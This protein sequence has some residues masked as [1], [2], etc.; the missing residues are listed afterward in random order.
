[1]NETI[2]TILNR[3]STR[4]FKPDMPSNEALEQILT[5]GLYAPS[6]MNTQNWHFSVVKNAEWIAR[7]NRAVREVLPEPA[8]ERM[9]AR[10]HGNPDFSLFYFAPVVIFVSAVAGDGGS[11]VN[12][13]LATQNICLA[14]ESLGLG[15]CI[16]GMAA[17]LTDLP[18]GPAYLKEIKIPEGYRPLHAISLGY[19]DMEMPAPARVPGKVEIIE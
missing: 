3:R 7:A 19:K 4:A 15:T 14:A 1:M 12:C 6:A 8:K 16:I 9:T 10:N 2:Q 17:M 11:A 18:V 13:A 5:C